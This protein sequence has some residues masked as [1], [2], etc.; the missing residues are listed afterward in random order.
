M[1]VG[2]CAE[3]YRRRHA[4]RLRARRARASEARL[5]LPGAVDLLVREF[6]ARRVVLFGSLLA[7]ELWD[8]SDVDLAV[9]GLF[10][11]AYFRALDRLGEVMGRPVD[12][13]P[14]EEAP[15]TLRDLV[16]REGEVLHGE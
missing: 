9:E 13:V 11:G 2:A 5:R 6:G 8:G 4:A 7:G 1:D 3:T 12:L 14:L 10:S 15:E 16:R